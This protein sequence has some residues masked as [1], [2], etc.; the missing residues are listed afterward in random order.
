MA[1]AREIAE[2]LREKL[3]QAIKQDGPVIIS[4]QTCRN[5]LDLLAYAAERE[6]LLAEADAALVGWSGH[7]RVGEALTYHEYIRWTAEALHR[8][9]ARQA[10]AQDEGKPTT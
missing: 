2:R 4:W 10:A 3:D 6:R 9:D 8:W 5:A 7:R 1:D